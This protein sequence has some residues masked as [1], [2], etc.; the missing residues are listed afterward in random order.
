[1]AKGKRCCSHPKRGGDGAN[2]W[3]AVGNTAYEATSSFGR[4]MQIVNVSVVT[5]ICT[6]LIIWSIF[7]MA[8]KTIYSASTN[9]I[10]Q[11]A[12]CKLNGAVNT[13]LLVI[14]F[15]A[16]STV[17]K[18]N[19]MV[20]NGNYQTGQTVKV[21]YDPANPNTFVFGGISKRMVGLIMFLISLIVLI[22]AW[23]WFIVVMLNKT[24][25]AVTG[26]ADGIG[27]IW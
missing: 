13:C 14:Q 12:D 3:N 24:A 4:I 16:G 15:T 2:D 1:M 25:A 19:P 17:I 21:R 7:L 20:M 10:V 26:A 18:S 5:L 6:P 27:M 8:S 11:S 22:I 23:I 9:A